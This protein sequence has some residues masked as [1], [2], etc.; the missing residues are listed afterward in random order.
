MRTM[1][2]VAKSGVSRLRIGTEARPAMIK[3]AQRHVAH[4]RFTQAPRLFGRQM[5]HGHHLEIFTPQQITVADIEGDQVHAGH[6]QQ[7]QRDEVHH[8]HGNEESQAH[9][10]SGNGRHFLAGRVG[11]VIGALDLAGDVV[12]IEACHQ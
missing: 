12:E 5:P 7:Q 2:A 8:Q 4:V 1:K 11:R 3:A 10:D 9:T 6:E